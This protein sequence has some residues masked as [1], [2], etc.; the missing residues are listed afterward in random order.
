MK[1]PLVLT[2]GLLVFGDTYLSQ[3]E[4]QSEGL[5]SR[6]AEARKANAQLH[7]FNFNQNNLLDRRANATAVTN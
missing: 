1:K 7:N 6:I 5:A 4:A 3:L 2:V